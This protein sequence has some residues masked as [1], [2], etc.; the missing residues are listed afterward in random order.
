MAHKL[1][2]Q[3]DE[4]LSIASMFRR[5]G[6]TVQ[7]QIDKIEAQMN[8]L[9]GDGWIGMGWDSFKQEMDSYVMPALRT[10]KMGFDEA[11]RQCRAVVQL[12]EDYTQQMIALFAAL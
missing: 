12:F 7:E 8:V 1:Q 2:L 11:E 3:D 9:D 5:I 4:M 6:D 10:M